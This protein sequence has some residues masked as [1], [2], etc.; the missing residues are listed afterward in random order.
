M[1][2]FNCNYPSTGAFDLG[3]GTAS[4]PY[5][6][7]TPEQFMLIGSTP[8]YLASHYVIGRNLDFASYV[9]SPIGESN[10][11]NPTKFP[12]TGS[13]DGNNLTIRNLSVLETRGTYAAGLFAH[14]NSAAIRN[15][16]LNN[17]NVEAPINS[18]LL[19]GHGINTSFE[20]IY[21]NGTLTRTA[22]VGTGFRFAALV[23]LYEFTTAGSYYV[24]DINI[25]ANIRSDDQTGMLFGRL[26]NTVSPGVNLVL[27]NISAVGSIEDITGGNTNGGIGGMITATTTDFNFTLNEI[28]FSGLLNFTRT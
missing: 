9:Y 18:A 8:A 27:E 7:C 23:G 6:V 5:V 25:N 11:S 1:Q 21:M 20:N 13:L 3:T 14:T 15:L 17:V 28:R 16:R 12:F 24:R 19:V 10:T 2:V 4:D 22:S 26:Y